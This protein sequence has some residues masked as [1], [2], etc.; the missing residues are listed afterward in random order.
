MNDVSV[1]EKSISTRE[2]EVLALVAQGCTNMEIGERLSITRTTVR[3]HLENIYNK[4]CVHDRT[5]AVVKYF[6]SAEIQKVI[7]GAGTL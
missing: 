3:T 7:G 5:E 6:F 1:A 4:L 2:R